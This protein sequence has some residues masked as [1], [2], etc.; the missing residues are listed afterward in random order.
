MPIP[1]TSKTF[2]QVEPGTYPARLIG[3]VDLGTQESTFEGRT[4]EARRVL[5]TFELVGELMEDERPFCYS[6]TYTTSLHKK[7]TLRRDL[8]S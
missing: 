3:I 1:M 4:T 7:S 6:R 5:F 2:K 8:E